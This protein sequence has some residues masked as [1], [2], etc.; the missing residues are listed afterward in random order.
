KSGGSFLRAE[1]VSEAPG[2]FSAAFTMDVYSNIIG[3]R[4]SGARAYRTRCYHDW[5]RR[6]KATVAPKL[7]TA[8]SR[9]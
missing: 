6:R 9:G 4:Q 2:H 5:K 7:D 3:G 8:P 1:A